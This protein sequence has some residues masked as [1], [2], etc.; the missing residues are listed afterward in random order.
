MP[1]E[2]NIHSG[3]R[4]LSSGLFAQAYQRFQEAIEEGKRFAQGDSLWGDAHRGLCRV[5]LEL[6]RFQEAEQASAIAL[7]TDEAFWGSDCAAVAEDLYLAGEAQRAQEK[8]ESAKSFYDRA[9]AYWSKQEGDQCESSLQVLSALVLLFLQSKREAGF[10]QLHA[11]CFAAYQSA[12]PTGMWMKFLRLAPVLEKYVEEGKHERAE[13]ILSCEITMLS[14]TLGKNHRELKPFLEYR[15]QLL[16]QSKQYLAAWRLTAQIGKALEEG[17]YFSDTRSYG[18]PPE[19]VIT[20]MSN[21]LASRGSFLPAN[22]PRIMHHTWWH[23]SKSDPLGH[24]LHAHLDL[25]DPKSQ[26]RSGFATTPGRARLELEIKTRLNGN[27][28]CSELNWHLLDAPD[29]STARDIRRFTLEEFDQTFL[30]LPGRVNRHLEAGGAHESARSWPTPQMY[31]EAI[32][33]ANQCFKD[34]QL[35]SAQPELNAI[36][37]PRPLSGAFG[38]VYRL[39][40]SDSQWAVKCFSQPV[41]D[42]QTRYLSVSRTLNQLNLPFFT[43][44]DYQADGIRVQSE[45]CYPVLKMSWVDGKSLNIAVASQLG[46]REMLGRISAAFINIA[47]IMESCGIAHG[48]LQHGNILVGPDGLMLVDYDCMF[49]PELSGM[50]SNEI[51]HRN[52]QHPGRAARHFGSYI[53]NFSVWV[54][55]VSLFVLSRYPQLWDM[56]ECGD[57]SLLFRQSDFE[58]PSESK[59]FQLLARHHDAEV[60]E[61]GATLQQFLDLQPERIP[62]VSAYFADRKTAQTDSNSKA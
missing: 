21:L 52:Y 33:N 25:V 47:K 15:S 37:L 28:T 27:T 42:Q 36:G 44:F 10:A 45:G 40:S 6:G 23:I 17:L 18:L 30:I 61:P 13:E 35:Q 1:W 32:Q 53:D 29:S 19:Q 20:V 59:V 51:G 58:R 46:N 5:C 62:S 50:E 7:E 14:G 26:A 34:P 16:Q 31:N 48:D 3:N 55:Y 4:A 54:I 24:Y 38:T 49:V 56:L 57:E 11:R 22:A 43:K 9:L 39:C 60:R 8:F 2:Q 41:T 12:H